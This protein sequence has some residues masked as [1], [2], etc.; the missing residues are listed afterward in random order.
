MGSCRDSRRSRVAQLSGRR[1]TAATQ[2]L[3]ART[4]RQSRTR[5]AGVAAR[6]SHA[7][8]FG[9]DSLQPRGHL[10]RHGEG[11]RSDGPTTAT[12]CASIPSTGMRS[13]T[14]A[15]CCACASISPRVRIASRPSNRRTCTTGGS[16]PRPGVVQPT[17]VGITR[18]R[19]ARL[20]SLAMP[21][22]EMKRISVAGMEVAVLQGAMET[23]A[24][25]KPVICVDQT[26]A[27]DALP[28]L[29]IQLGYRVFVMNARNYIC[30]HPAR[31]LIKLTG[32][33]EVTRRPPPVLTGSSSARRNVRSRWPTASDGATRRFATRGSWVCRG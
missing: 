33:E 16:A 28:S 3:V 21:R 2:R 24:R 30:V 5:A 12:A 20:D 15:S 17:S 10:H 9:A 13:G 8:G 7:P 29:L 19:Q 14:S 31:P 32:L 1:R 6:C 23:I 25:C 22:I 4:G 18:V 26:R 11:R 27:G